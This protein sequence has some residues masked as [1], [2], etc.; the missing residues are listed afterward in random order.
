L[1]YKFAI[2]NSKFT[3][4]SVALLAA[5]I[6]AGPE[7]R[8]QDEYLGRGQASSSGAAAPGEGAAGEGEL[9]APSADVTGAPVLSIVP[10][11]AVSGTYDT[12]V[13]FVENQQKDDFVTRI[14]P[15]V[16]AELKGRL[17][18]GSLQAGLTGA[19]YVHNP[20]LNYL[21]ANGGLNLN[22]DNLVNRVIPRLKVQLADFVGYSP[23]PPA[24]LNPEARA[25]GQSDI[26]ARGIQVA[27]ADSIQNTTSI[28]GSYTLLPRISLNAAYS[29]SFMKFFNAFATPD[30]GTFVD[31]TSH[32]ASVGVQT[33][34]TRQDNLSVS[35]AYSLSSFGEGAS[36]V[37]SFSSHSGAL[38]WARRFTPTLSGSLAG[39]ATAAVPDSGP[40]SLNFTGSATLIWTQGRVPFSFNLSRAVVP[41]NFVAGTALISDTV[42]ISAG[43]PLTQRLAVTGSANYGQNSSSFTGTSLDFYSVGGTIGFNYALLPGINAH[44]TYN[45]NYFSQDSEGMSSQFNRHVAAFAI[46]ALWR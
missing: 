1:S 24:F 41:S 32:S 12:N 11:V 8:A 18:S 17:M 4:A 38:T 5:I 10:S 44:V 43:F 19:F 29:Y 22:L 9:G 42:S 28:T 13:L 33:A 15:Q 40:S 31:T 46:S 36:G 7:G 20:D 26:F 37:G 14:T 6:G 2:R 23:Q 16:T 30:A 3:I 27:R 39:G 25:A 21:G 34:V 35:Y 45:Y